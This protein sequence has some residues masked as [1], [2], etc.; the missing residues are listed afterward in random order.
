DILDGWKYR[1][2]I[3]LDIFSIDGYGGLGEAINSTKRIAICYF[4]SLSLT[5]LTFSIPLFIL[6]YE[7]DSPYEGKA[8]LLMEVSYLLQ[9]FLYVILLIL[10][11]YYIGSTYLRISNI[12][13]RYLL[14]ESFINNKIC[15][16]KRNKLRSM[17]SEHSEA[18]NSEVIDKLRTDLEIIF[19]DRENL[20]KSTKRGYN[21]SAILAIAGSFLSSLVI[22]ILTMVQLIQN[23]LDKG[24]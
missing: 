21:L 9:I 12:F 17:L 4:T 23:I 16:E 19:E 11:V 1:S 22:P 6:F 3:R 24:R 10:G 2:L 14:D 15:N 13:N 18:I 20:I 5:I 7:L 8:K